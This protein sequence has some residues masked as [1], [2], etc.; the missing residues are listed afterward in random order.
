M[1]TVF[2]VILTALGALMLLGGGICTATNALF[3]TSEGSGGA[4]LFIVLGGISAAIALG[5][6]F[7]IKVASAGDE[8]DGGRGG[9]DDAGR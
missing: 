4:A 7:L 3:L 8:K 9:F 2:K 1:K 5:G 6:F